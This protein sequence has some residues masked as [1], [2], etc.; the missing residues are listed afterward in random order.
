MDSNLQEKENN[1]SISDLV[2]IARGKMDLIAENIL[3]MGYSPHDFKEVLSNLI[4]EEME[5]IERQHMD[6][7]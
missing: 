1:P 2:N 3:E 7:D 6:I 5:S 4:Y